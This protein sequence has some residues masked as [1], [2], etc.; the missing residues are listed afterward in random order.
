M[1][2]LYG[3]LI[4]W[5]VISWI[6]FIL[7]E[8]GCVDA[9]FEDKALWFLF[10]PMWILVIIILPITIYRE[11]YYVISRMKFEEIKKCNFLY[12]RM[13][14]HWWLCRLYGNKEKHPI[15]YHLIIPMYIKIKQTN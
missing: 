3:A 10:A 5:V 4:A 2:Y 7:V 1:E 6:F 13:S 12:K 11:N 9:F 15:L 8:L 14:R